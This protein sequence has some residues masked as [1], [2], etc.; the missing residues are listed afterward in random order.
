E[1]KRSQ[2]S[3]FPL[4]LL[5]SRQFVVTNVV[6][7]IVYAALG[8]ALFLLPVQLQVVDHYS[9]IEAGLSLLPLT[10]IM[11]VFSSRSGRLAAR[12]GPRLQ[13][14]VGPVIVGLG[15]ALLARTSVD[16]FYPSG[17]LPAVV[18]FGAGLAVTVAPLTSTALNSVED[19]RAGLAS[20]VNND[21]ARVGGL[22]AV[23]AL[24]ALA[25][26]TGAS[27]LHPEQFSAGFRTAVL[28]SAGICVLGGVIAA[29]GIRNPVK[30]PQ[31]KPATA[32]AVGQH[33]VGYLQGLH[34]SL[35]ATPL[36]GEA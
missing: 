15:L 6:T 17:V 18:V 29:I 19:E 4:A 27:Y 1:R 23:A 14:G 24:P 28:I 36:A 2:A 8:G 30:A 13:M 12:I 33:R 26:I 3:M 9:P 22:V 20:A 10:V 34:C 11:L 21:V 31:L 5:R 35:D 25:G 16:S 7:F 32:P